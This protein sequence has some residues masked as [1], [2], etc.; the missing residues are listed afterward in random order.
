MEGG[1]DFD[2]SGGHYHVV[3]NLEDGVDRAVEREVGDGWLGRVIGLVTNEVVATYA[4]ASTG[5]IK[6]GGVTVEV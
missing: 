3:E 6:V 1:A 2:F 5:F 4:D